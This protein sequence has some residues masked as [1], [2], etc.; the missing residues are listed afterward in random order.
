LTLK[1]DVLR[2]GGVFTPFRE[3][4]KQSAKASWFGQMPSSA[5]VFT[6]GLKTFANFTNLAA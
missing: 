1:N 5:E 3:F 4:F 6:G 2:F